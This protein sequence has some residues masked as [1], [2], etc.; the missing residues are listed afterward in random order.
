MEEFM[1]RALRSEDTFQAIAHPLRRKI[2]LQLSQGN[3]S[4]S[5]IAK[6]FNVSLP[7]ISQQL[8]VLKK[9][10]LVEETRIGRQRIYQLRPKPL[11]EVF[12]WVEFFEDFW[13]LKL[14]ALG[15]YLDAKHK[16]S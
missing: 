15:K 16:K 9:V 11:K 6:P 14:D 13:T 7:A 10:G 5:E 12:E 1:V 2:L 8:N 4:A 3:K